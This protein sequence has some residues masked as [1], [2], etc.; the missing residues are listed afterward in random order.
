MGQEGG[1]GVFA[2]FADGAAPGGFSAHVAGGHM[3][4]GL[5]YDRWATVG[6]N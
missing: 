6:A 2:A 3:T 5:V 1:E 4:G